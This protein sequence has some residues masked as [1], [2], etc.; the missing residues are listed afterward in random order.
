MENFLVKNIIG[1]ML[2][3]ILNWQ[4]PFNWNEWQQEK[5]HMCISITEY[6]YGTNKPAWRKGKS[7]EKSEGDQYDGKPES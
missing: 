2:Q 7:R 3:L 5:N 1:E 4:Q 6:R